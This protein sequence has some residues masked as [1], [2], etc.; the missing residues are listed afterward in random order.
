MTRDY[1]RLPEMSYEHRPAAFGEETLR[2]PSLSADGRSG[3][4]D[5]FSRDNAALEAAGARTHRASETLPR[6]FLDGRRA[7]TPDVES[8]GI[9]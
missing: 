6:H 3:A 4:V 7:D 2:R 5:P 8:R 9:A 1:P